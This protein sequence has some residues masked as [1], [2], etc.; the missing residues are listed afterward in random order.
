MKRFIEGADRHQVTLLP[1]CL[2]DYV[3]E[4]N[5]VRIVDAFVGELDLH[6]LGFEGADPAATGRPAY[7]PS[8]LLKLYIYGYLNRIQSSRRLEREAQ[9]NIE[10]MWLTGRL[11]PDFKT[12]A[13]FRHDNGKG[14]RN[15][16]RRFI[17]LCR[18]LKLF[19]QAV[20]A[21]DG[22]KF[23][24]VNSRDRNFSPGKIDG[25]QQ[26]IERSI[27]RYLDALETADRTQPAD[28][29]A[30]TERLQEKISK[31]REQMR[32]LDETRE[33]LKSEPD[34]QRSLTDPD[35]RSMLQTGK[36]TGLVG[37]NIQAAVDGK[38][39]LIVAHEVTNVGHDRAQ[40]TKMALAAR[41][42]MGK[43]KLNAFADR[44]YFN[45]LEIKACED[46]GITA[47]VPKPMTSNAKAHGRFGK[48]DFIYI[49]KDD[50]YLCP[51]GQRA[52]YRCSKIDN[53]L[54]NRLYWPSACPTCSLKDKCTTS[55]FRQIRRWEH[56]AVIDRMQLRLDRKPGAMTLRRSTI[57][58]VFGT[59]KHW[60]GTAPF[61]T[62]TMAHVDTEMSLQVL[63]YNLKRVTNV[64]GIARTM[65]AMR[66]AGA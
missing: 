38:H 16:C 8:V 56:E 19:S 57:E 49:A 48:A 63:A 17:V 4:D 2:D 37:Y 65:K 9:R 60:M 15:V 26:Q 44:G 35:A 40:L 20:V 46:A 27:Q 13:D 14:I 47:F 11:T 7:H 36:S 50:E 30:K 10:L 24:A 6:A 42:A 32:Q 52:I 5:P 34:Q 51:A 31:L 45:N 12:I 33:Q 62:K 55:S 39:H 61:L 43:S 3:G 25:R 28:L 21:I 58:H 53:N 64:L 54:R 59:L 23:K 18:Q 29:E 41:D 1:E 22:S 66:L